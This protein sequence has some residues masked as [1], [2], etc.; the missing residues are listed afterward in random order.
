MK[1]LIFLIVPTVFSL[2]SFLTIHSERLGD[3]SITFTVHFFK[4]KEIKT[5]F[6][7]WGHFT[8][9]HGPKYHVGFSMRI[10]LVVCKVLERKVDPWQKLMVND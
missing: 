5:N 4:Y 9:Q 1:S 3:S 2:S 6:E 8:K 10:F 7:N